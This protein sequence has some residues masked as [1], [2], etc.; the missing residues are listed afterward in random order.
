MHVLEDVH[1]NLPKGEESQFDVVGM[2]LNAVDWIVQLPYFPQRNSKVQIKEFKRIAGG[3]VATAM[4]LCGRYGLRTRYIGRVGD[5]EIGEFSLLSL[6]SE[7]IDISM[8]EVIPGAKS[9]YA[10]ILVDP[11]GQRTVLWD[12]DPKLTY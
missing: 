11:D 7:P 6:K 4:V 12:R 5:D 8:V 3:Q 2:G 9:Q 10:V 1:F